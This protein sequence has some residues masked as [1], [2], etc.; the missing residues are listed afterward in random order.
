VKTELQI[1]G[2]TC[3]RCQHHVETALRQ[4]PGVTQVAVM[5]AQGGAAIEHDAQVS[6]DALCAAVLAAGYECRPLTGV[7]ASIGEA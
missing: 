6:L 5:L 3:Q 2:M 1:T 4:Q 7:G